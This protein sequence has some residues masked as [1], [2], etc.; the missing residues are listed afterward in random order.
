MKYD[1]YKVFI[2]LIFGLFISESSFSLEPTV[3]SARPMVVVIDPG[4]GGKDP[5]AVNKSIREK[6]VVL[7]IGLK[8]GKLLNESY[9]DVKV[10]Y[11]RSTDV[12]VPL[13]DRSRIANKNKA[14][15]FIS[16][17]ANYCA[18][19]ST[20]GTE[21]FTLGLHRSQDNLDVAKKENSVILLEENYSE[22]YEGFDPNVTE[23][24]I[25]FELV[26]DA[27]MD[28][29]LSFADAIQNQFKSR[30][31]TPNRGV[32]QAGFLVLRQ[33]SMPSVLVEAGFLSNQAEANY[34]SSDEGQRNIAVSIFEA[35]R[36]IKSKNSGAS[37]P[38][39]AEKMTPVA[40]NKPSSKQ[41]PEVIEKAKEKKPAEKSEIIE[42]KKLGLNDQQQKSSSDQTN[43]PQQKAES[44]IQNSKPEETLAVLAVTDL[45]T[46]YS[47]QIGANTIPVEPTASNFK[48][49]KEVRR[50]KTDK[51]YR[52]YIGKETSFEKITPIWQQI[53]QKFPQAFIVS[54]TN[55]KRIIIDNKPKS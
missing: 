48:G 54:F 22:T 31:S 53:K 42:E 24:Y 26:Q 20:R 43:L 35:F 52:Y 38:L 9:S 6:D 46:Y 25:M 17:H 33:S 3:K 41:E 50:E 27:Y 28:Q 1:Y 11:T 36:K 40:S 5:G 49:L 44:K 7:G 34:L 8:L 14:D 32:K 45:G 18:T 47:V 39:I 55:G 19:P 13:I 51:Y 21:T 30:F 10:V 4:H 2:V 12:F 37:A 15:L 23:S 29:S 16:I